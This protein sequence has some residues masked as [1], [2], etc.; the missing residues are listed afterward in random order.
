MN[1]AKGKLIPDSQVT[2]MLAIF[3]YNNVRDGKDASPKNYVLDVAT[4]NSK[5]HVSEAQQAGNFHC[6]HYKVNTTL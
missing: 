4:K 6:G 3:S 2:N 5:Q 1:F